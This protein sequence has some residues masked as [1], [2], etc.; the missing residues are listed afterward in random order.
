MAKPDRIYEV[1]P[2][3][4][5][6]NWGFGR[7]LVVAKTLSRLGVAVV[8]PINHKGEEIEPKR[9]QMDLKFVHNYYKIMPKRAQEEILDDEAMRLL[10]DS[11]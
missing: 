11:V 7:L 3:A 10:V 4:I 1:K 2:E 6:P 9:H 8:I 5:P